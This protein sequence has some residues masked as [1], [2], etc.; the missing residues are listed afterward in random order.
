MVAGVLAMYVFIKYIS[1]FKSYMEIY[2][3]DKT[4]C[5]W[6]FYA[7]WDAVI[8]FWE[9]QNSSSEMLKKLFSKISQNLQKKIYA[10]V[11]SPE[12]VFSCKSKKM[13]EKRFFTERRLATAFGM[14]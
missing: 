4:L 2:R 12:Q 1:A 3:L 14:N 7:V 9:L 8:W 10:G 6:A 13:F 5:P 11:F